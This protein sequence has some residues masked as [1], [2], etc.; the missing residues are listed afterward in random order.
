M[1]LH[2]FILL[3]LLLFQGAI[4]IPTILSLTSRTNKCYEDSSKV[5]KPDMTCDQLP[6]NTCFYTV[7]T[8][9]KPES[10]TT[11]I[12]DWNCVSYG[13]DHFVFNGKKASL[14]MDAGPVEV[15]GRIWVVSNLTRLNAP[16]SNI[17][18]S[19]W[20]TGSCSF[21]Q[22]KWQGKKYLV[23][24]SESIEDALLSLM[25]LVV[26]SHVYRIEIPC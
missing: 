2:L 25:P 5:L 14:G 24:L 19:G 22:L 13:E 11:S 15:K 16:E 21:P 23:Y 1:Y 26:K 8:F 7:T 12:T 17:G 6:E 9:L 4:S 10:A 3:W 18:I 20:Y